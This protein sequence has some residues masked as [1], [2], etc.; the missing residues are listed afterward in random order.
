VE[1]I[2]ASHLTISVPTSFVIS[3]GRLEPSK[4]RILCSEEQ[5]Q[6]KTP[7]NLCHLFAQ[8]AS[9]VDND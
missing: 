7:L 8:I 3:S 6:Y 2:R 9:G 5:Q 1:G 4:E